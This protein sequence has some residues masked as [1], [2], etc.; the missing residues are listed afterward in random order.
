[1]FQS[2]SYGAVFGTVSAT[3]SDSADTDVSVAFIRR[4]VRDVNQIQRLAR[5]APVSVAFIRRGVRDVS[6]IVLEHAKQG[7]SV[8]FIRR[9]VRDGKRA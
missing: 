6:M 3:L 1:M 9:G 4:G 5:N 7:V 8:A 2:P